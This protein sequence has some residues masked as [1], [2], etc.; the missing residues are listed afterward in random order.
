MADT[1]HSDHQPIDGRILDIFDTLTEGERRLA[2]VVLETQ[3]RLHSFTASELAARAQVSNATAARFFQHLGYKS[4]SQ[5]RLQSRR[6]EAWGSPLY[7]LSRGGDRI[8]PDDLFHHIAQDVQN[9]SRTASL[10]RPELLREAISILAAAPTVWAIGF[11]NSYVL[12][13]YARALLV[14]VKP[15]VRLL[16]IAGMTLAEDFIGIKP[17]DALFVVGFRRRPAVLRSLIERAREIGAKSVFV[18]DLTAARSAQF[19]TVTLRC[20]SRSHSL[21][22]SYAAPISVINH[23]CAAVGLARGEETAARL[24]EIE[25]LHNLVDQAGTPAPSRNQR[26]S[27]QR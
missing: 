16:P 23:V 17:D 7:E 8:Q 15:D 24:A 13:N 9:L 14:H 19:A 26:K 12:A 25:R 18:T 20:H 1:T 22:D 21:F 27:E 6:S 11:R 10:I 3:G 4:Y 5:A 2:E